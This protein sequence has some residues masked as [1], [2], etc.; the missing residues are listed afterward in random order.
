MQKKVLI[1]AFILCIVILNP[2]LIKLFTHQIEKARYET[3]PVELIPLRASADLQ[4]VEDLDGDGYKEVILRENYPEIPGRFQWTIFKMSVKTYTYHY[5][6]QFL[7]PRYSFLFKIEKQKIKGENE[8]IFKFLI[9][10]NFRFFIEDYNNRG[11]FLRSYP[12]QP[13]SYKFPPDFPPQLFKLNYCQLADLNGDGEKDL[14]GSLIAYYRRYPRALIAYDLKTGKLLWEYYCGSAPIGYPRII[15]IDSDGHPEIV[16]GTNALNNGAVMNGISDRYSYLIVLDHTGR[17]RWKRILG[18]WYTGIFVD[19]MDFNGDGILEIVATKQCRRAVG[20]PFGEIW[21]IE[22]KTGRI[23]RNFSKKLIS[24]SA[25]YIA[26]EE[27]VPYIFVGDSEGKIWKFTSELKIAKVVDLGEPVALLKPIPPFD[28]RHI[29]ALSPYHLFVLTKSLRVVFKYKFERAS[30]YM[31]N[32]GAP[33]LSGLT[34][35]YEDKFKIKTI[36]GADQL[37][38]LVIRK[39]KPFGEKALAY[40]KEGIPFTLLAFVLFNFLSFYGLIMT[41]KERKELLLRTIES[42]Q[43]WSEVMQELAHRMRTPLSTL[44]WSLEKL[45]R[46]SRAGFTDKSG[47]ISKVASM[48]EDIEKLRQISLNMMKLFSIHNLRLQKI[49]IKEILCSLVDKFHELLKGKI[50]I[51]CEAEDNLFVKADPELFREAILNLIQNSIEAMPDGG[52]LILNA[53]AVHNV[54][55]G[56]MKGV[57][58]EVEDTGCGID[59]S[60]LDKIFKPNYST[61]KK[62]MGIGLTITKRIVEA[63]HGNIKVFSKKGVGTKIAIYLPAGEN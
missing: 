20:V 62:G 12:L 60:E 54:L 51:Q 18:H 9:P 43:Q 14:I 22:G 23:L 56:K 28:W 49:N 2:L 38:E 5:L 1:G 37:Y 63:H 19:L 58:V 42:F 16:F 8:L 31:T 32:L 34:P 29:I 57:V 40:F 45:K 48:E 36:I 35:A 7:V 39:S 50:E 10:R 11:E 27:G 61:K 24:F 15:D 13:L 25:P 41:L 47:L 46:I 21:I 17:E 6:G 3:S 33:V 4:Y 53:Y 52:K 44:L 59:E 30:I 55:T 26:K